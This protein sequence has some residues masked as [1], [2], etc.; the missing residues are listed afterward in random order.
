MVIMRVIAIISI[1]LF[2]GSLPM[3]PS[4]DTLSSLIK[5]MMMNLYRMMYYSYCLI[6]HQDQIFPID[7]LVDDHYLIFIHLC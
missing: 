7:L 3:T 4:L 6:N 1:L 5:M 2:M